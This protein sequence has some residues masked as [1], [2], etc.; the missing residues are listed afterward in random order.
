MVVAAALALHTLHNKEGGLPPNTSTSLQFNSLTF[1]TWTQQ[2]NETFSSTYEGKE[3]LS[4]NILE[5]F[6]DCTG[7]L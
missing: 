3:I 1:E 2:L 4:N 6:R 7:S 5:S